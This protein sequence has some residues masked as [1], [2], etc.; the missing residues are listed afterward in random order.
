MF[1]IG[2]G[3]G[4]AW[5][6]AIRVRLLRSQDQ[7]RMEFIGGTRGAKSLWELP[8]ILLCGSQSE[9]STGG[10]Q[11]DRWFALRR[12][13]MTCLSCNGNEGVECQSCQDSGEVEFTRLIFRKLCSGDN[14]TKSFVDDNDLTSKVVSSMASANYSTSAYFPLEPRSETRSLV[15]RIFAK[16][17][18][19]FQK[20]G[21]K[22]DQFN[23]LYKDIFVPTDELI[24]K[25]ITGI[26]KPLTK[27]VL[28]LYLL[29][30]SNLPPSAQDQIFCHF[31]VNNGFV[32][33]A[34]QRLNW[35]RDL[36]AQTPKD[37]D[38]CAFVNAFRPEV[39]ETNN[40]PP[41]ALGGEPN[42]NNKVSRGTNPS[43]FRTRGERGRAWSILE[44]AM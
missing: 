31:T 2:K 12:E 25:F 11:K 14:S 21:D 3:L 41:K 22:S 38:V 43:P 36:D 5:I 23:I 27:K 34:A 35:F 26:G 16:P 4:P 40:Q 6:P 1:T 10:F 39:V 37:P 28:A 44:Q 33:P 24:N 32:S 8:E 7:C 42:T 9:G 18:I 19:F 13:K 30:K 29:E 20:D 15:E 17:K